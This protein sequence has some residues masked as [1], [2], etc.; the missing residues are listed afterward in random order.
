M[1]VIPEF[2]GKGFGKWVHRHGFMMMKAQGGKLYHG[3]T[4]GENLPMRKLFESH[5]C[6]IFC[7]LEEWGVRLDRDE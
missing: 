1:G 7:E 5:G 2:R 6:K 3:G 4:H